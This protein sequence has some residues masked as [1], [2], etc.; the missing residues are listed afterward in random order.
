MS[1][2]RGK[3]AFAA[4]AVASF[5]LSA[6]PPAEL[7]TAPGYR[8]CLAKTTKVPEEAFADAAAW[9]DGGGG[10]P[11]EHCA[12]MAL[13]SLKRSAEAAERL[14]RIARDAAAGPAANRAALFGQ[15]GNAWLLA[16]QGRNAEA[17]F[18]AALR[19]TPRNAE[20][21]TD[22]SRARAM[23]KNWK[24]AE[25]D[26]SAAL[27]FGRRAEMYVL[28][29]A[30]RRAQNRLKDA[31]ADIDAALAIDPRHADALV[32]RGSLKL[33]A[34]DKQGAR[35]DWLQVLLIAPDGSAGDEARRRIEDLEID[36]NR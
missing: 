26:L 30:T 23:L 21:W 29:A 36:P 14:V 15:A 4:A 17:A 1:V 35:R 16:G 19:L 8:A 6:S 27:M 22:R 32:E 9:R 12:A 2:V 34:G 25:F 3:R 13:L 11:A 5:T 28:R 33:I 7:F 18:T 24:G 10:P 20:F 31:R